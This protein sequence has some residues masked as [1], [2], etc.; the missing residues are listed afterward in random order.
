MGG[1][2]EAL[3]AERPDPRVGLQH[4]LNVPEAGADGA[5]ASG[6]AR[7]QVVAR[8]VELDGGRRQ[9]CGQVLLDTGRTD[10]S[11][12]AAMWHRERLVQVEL[13]HVE[14]GISGAGHAEDAVRVGLVVGAQPSRVVDHANELR[15]L[16]VEDP[17][18]LGIRDHQP[19][20]PLTD[21][22]LQRI[23]LGIPLSTG[24]ERDHLEPDGGG[25]GRVGRVGEDGGDDLV[26]LRRLAIGGVV[27]SH[28]QRV[29]KDALAPAG[30]LE[31]E[32]VHPGDLGEHLTEPIEELEDPLDRR[33]VL[34]RV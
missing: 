30:R 7:V 6:A 10:G 12:H 33:F 4:G 5:D 31:R 18:V 26:P 17:G 29:R 21:R 11:A 9:E 34:S 28:H 19:G 25:G 13:A 20:R 23:Q 1:L 24:I 14:P 15:D 3:G 27:R 16:R 22:P 2:P 32:A 8:A